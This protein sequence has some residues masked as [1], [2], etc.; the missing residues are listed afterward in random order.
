MHEGLFKSF[1]VIYIVNDKNTLSTVKQQNKLI[2][3]TKVF[4]LV[5][6]GNEAH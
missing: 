1:L 2:V 5:L 3:L 4:S 6:L